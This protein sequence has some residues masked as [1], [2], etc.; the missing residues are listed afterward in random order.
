MTSLLCEM[1]ASMDVQTTCFATWVDPNASV[2]GCEHDL[3]RP[4]IRRGYRFDLPNRVLARQAS[5]FIRRWDPD[6]VFVVGLTNL[7]GYLLQSRIANRVY[8][9]ELTNAD[10]GNKFVAPM[11]AKHIAR[12]KAVLS[13]SNAIDHSIRSTYDY[14]GEIK[15]LPF[16]VE[17]DQDGYVQSPGSFVADFLFLARREDDKGLRE[18]IQATAM[19]VAVHPHVRVLVGGPGDDTRY[20][21]LARELGVE[22][23]IIFRSLPSRA[24]AMETLAASRYLVLPSYHEGYPL[25]L[26]EAA[27]KSV[28][29]I[30]TDVGSIRET[31]SPCKGCTIIPAKDARSLC[32]A[33]RMQLDVSTQDYEV[34]RHAVRNRFVELSSKMSVQFRIADLINLDAKY[35]AVK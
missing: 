11:A 9:W 24:D 3:V 4:L 27:Q 2:T 23:N 14:Q 7:C 1:L 17:E 33:M 28:P 18:L 20:Q 8:V 5:R 26:L 19:L 12:S 31:F 35:Q 6:A 30:A 15:R 16:W 34:S 22:G 21:R 29:F 10:A 32:D 13:P 25:S